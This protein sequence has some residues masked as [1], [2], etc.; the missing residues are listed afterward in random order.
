MAIAAYVA[1]WR[2]DAEASHTSDWQAPELARYASGDALQV[3]TR[4]LYAD[5]Y[6]GL[7]S[8][9]APVNNPKATA[10]SPAGTPT[11][12]MIND[13]SDS[14]SWVRVK[15]DGTPF[16]DTPG[17]TRKIVAVVQK[18]TDGLWRVTE[19]G[20]GAVGSC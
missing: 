8:R 11:S 3:L 5:H 14:R 9:G 17:G 12:V 20:V 16:T 6:N 19:V 1:M 18:H 4:G 10:V 7:I 2:A 13:C 15:A